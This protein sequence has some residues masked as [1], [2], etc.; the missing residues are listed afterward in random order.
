MRRKQRHLA[1]PYR[2]LSPFPTLCVGIPNTVGEEAVQIGKVWI[3]VA[4][5]VQ[6]FA[7]VLARPFAIPR[8]PPRIIRVEVR[9][10]Q[11]LPAAMRTGFNVAARAM[12]LADGR[13]AI[14]TGSEFLAQASVSSSTSAAKPYTASCAIIRWS[15]C[16]AV[17]HL[18]DAGR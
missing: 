18:R 3:A 15:L 11:C 4:V 17:E 5:E 13:T 2:S 12:A 16:G 8:L 14:G 9:A 10:A 7:I 6:A 1:S